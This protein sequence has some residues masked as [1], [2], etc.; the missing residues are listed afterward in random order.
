MDSTR[1]D[2]ASCPLPE[3]IIPRY[4]DRNKGPKHR[5]DNGPV[6]FTRWVP[7]GRSLNSCPFV[8]VSGAF[9]S[10]F[11]RDKIC[12]VVAADTVRAMWRQLQMALRLT[13]TAELRLDWLAND[14]E[15][16]RFLR[17]LASSKSR[18]LSS[19]TL[20]ATCRRRAAGGRFQGSIARQ[21]LCLSQA[22]HSGCSWY[23]LEIETSSRCSAELLDA[24]L[25]TGRRLA[26]AHF[27]RGMPEDLKRVASRLRR[28]RPDAI[29]IAARCDS[30]AAARQFVRMAHSSRDVVA[31]PMGDVALPVRVLAPRLGSALAYAPVENATA[32]GQIR[33][34][35]LFHIYRA[36]AITRRCRVYGVIGNPIAHSLSPQMQNAGFAARGIDAV[37][38]PFLV[39][40][41][42]DFVGAL[43]PLGI[44]GFSVTI[45][46]KEVILRH[47]DECDP[48]ARAVGAVNTV[49]VRGGGKLYGYNTDYIGV[50]RTLE[51]RIPLQASR[52]LILGAGGAARAVA[53][54]LAQGGAHVGIC[55]RRPIKARQLARAVGGRPIARSNLSREF[56]DAIVNTTPVGM[57]PRTNESPLLAR[58]LNC[59]LLF[60]TIYR[61]QVTKLMQLARRR[62]IETI[63]GL[64]MFLAQ[65]TAQWEIWTGERA[66][67]AAMRRAVEKA[68][69][70]EGKAAN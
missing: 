42:K 38:L 54:A 53:F 1:Q 27:F 60:D 9:V 31:V 37:Y 65:G 59:R 8:Q 58:E 36:D 56:F 67:V 11:G 52:V 19:A 64:E 7:H 21:L 22:L 41:L 49:V 57:H 61:P 55:A 16:A 28:N 29:K 13:Q 40:D 10:L 69:A 70:Q 39:R 2:G 33:L 30:L 63:S 17:R 24:L 20:I 66:P 68:L 62:G 45:P 43:Q 12:A 32:P 47:L 48:L 50:L 23:D 34:H 26:S 46:H 15:I 18:A 35:D 5:Q 14:A 25:G 51:R 4:F 6:G 3:G 44:H